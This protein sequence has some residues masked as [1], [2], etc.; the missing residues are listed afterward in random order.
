MICSACWSYLEAAH[1]GQVHH[2]WRR[3][4]WSTDFHLKSCRTSRAGQDRT[5]SQPPSPPAARNFPLLL[6]VR[7]LTSESFCNASCCVES[8]ADTYCFTDMGQTVVRKHGCSSLLGVTA[9]CSC[10]CQQNVTRFAPESCTSSSMMVPS[11]ALHSS[12][13]RRPAGPTP[14]T[15]NFPAGW[16]AMRTA[17]FHPVLHSAWAWAASVSCSSF[18]ANALHKRRSLA[19][20]L[21]SACRC[22]KG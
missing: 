4:K 6:N 17:V 1:K 18:K 11:S 8:A 3:T 16:A 20:P 12:K 10:M 9:A 7:P 13:T 21:T 2:V 15:T 5:V 19:A 22:V 14:R